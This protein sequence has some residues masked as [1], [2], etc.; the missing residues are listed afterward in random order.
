[1][2]YQIKIAI[3]EIEPPIW[4]RLKI[5][6]SITFAQL[7][8]IIQVA[9]EWLGY[10][11]YHFRFDNIIVVEPDPDFTISELYGEEIEALRS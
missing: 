4:R 7:H 6:G 9:F 10:H 8:R 1:M 11:L 2:A 5:P 3:C